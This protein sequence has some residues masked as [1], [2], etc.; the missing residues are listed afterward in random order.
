MV[1]TPQLPN[2]I[3]VTKAPP[4]STSYHVGQNVPQDVTE[5][6]CQ[7]R[8][9]QYIC[10][11]AVAY[12]IP[13]LPRARRRRYQPVDLA[14]DKVL[15]LGLFMITTV[16]IPNYVCIESIIMHQWQTTRNLLVI[17]FRYV[18]EMLVVLPEQ[19]SRDQGR[20]KRILYEVRIHWLL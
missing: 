9:T 14:K 4:S 20:T 18:S 6:G 1:H 3:L 19:C 2:T 7:T 8:S 5:R 15:C 17:Q 13:S 12:P 11:A 16:V 10:I